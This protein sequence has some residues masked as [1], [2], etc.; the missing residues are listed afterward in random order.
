MTRSPRQARAVERVR[1]LGRRL[2]PD[3][4][5]PEGLDDYAERFFDHLADDFNTPA[6]RGVLFEWVS[7]ANRRLDAGERVAV[8]AD[9]RRCSMPSASRDCWKNDGAEAPDPAAQAPLGAARGGP[10]RPRTSSEADRLR[11]ELAAMG[12]EVRDTAD[13]AR[14]VRLR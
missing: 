9:S 4:P 2:D 1:E 11:D 6:A 12:Y 10:E 5:A 3:A 7:E 14:L 13:G 8:P